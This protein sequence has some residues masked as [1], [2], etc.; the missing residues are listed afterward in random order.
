MHVA[1]SPRDLALAAA[2][3]FGFAGE[4]QA[5]ARMTVHT[6]EKGDTLWGLSKR[7]GCSIEQLRRANSGKES[8]RIGARLQM[9]WCGATTPPKPKGTQAYVV[10]PGDTLSEIAKKQRTTL[11]R[12]RKL[13]ELGGR[14]MIVVGQTLTL[15]G[16]APMKPVKVRVVKGQSVG[17]PHR[18]RLRNGVQLPRDPA[19]YRRRPSKAYGAQHAVDHTRAAILAVK[20]KV[21]GARRVAI[22][23]LS[24]KRG[25]PI[26]GHRSHQ[27]GRDVDIGLYFKRDPSG[28]PKEFAHASSGRL[29]L[30]ANWALIESLAAASAKAGGPEYIFLDYRVQSRLYK[31]ALDKG[32][33][34][35]KLARIFQYPH[36]RRKREGLVRHESNHADHV[37]VR[38]R[39][40]ASD[41]K[42]R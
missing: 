9:P 22:G 36:G 20:H 13:N 23:D 15:P 3:M 26:S 8:L 31:Y 14:S 29:D 27:S 35:K 18:G 42:C 5:E 4:V 34:K 21:P 17:K 19:Y 25:G 10:R 33:S 38:Y 30:A 11:E 28:Y 6:V 24:S 39:C 12:I 1:M 41:A 2:V 16:A 40:P 7:T 37:H 32:V